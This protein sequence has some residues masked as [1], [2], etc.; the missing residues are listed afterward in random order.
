M[1][2]DVVDIRCL[3]DFRLELTFD[4]GNS[5][6]L[7]C[8]PIIAK[9]GVF[10]VRRHPHVFNKAE[11]HKELGVITWNNEVDIAPETAY[12]LATGAPLPEW[13]EKS[14]RLI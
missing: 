6:I 8:K 13:M 3:D 1:Y 9:G 5:G 11:I 4:D 10:S 7:D 12:S 14:E 2:H